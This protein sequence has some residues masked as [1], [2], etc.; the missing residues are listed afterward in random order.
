MWLLIQPNM[1]HIIPQHMSNIKFSKGRTLQNQSPCFSIMEAV[2]RTGTPSTWTNVNIRSLRKSS[3]K[4]R[5]GP[6]AVSFDTRWI[7]PIQSTVTAK[8]FA[9][10]CSLPLPQ[11]QP[12]PY[13]WRKTNSWQDPRQRVSEHLNELMW[14]RSPHNAE[15]F[16][17]SLF[18]DAV[19]NWD[20]SVE[21]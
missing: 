17:H 6:E 14:W 18:N 9:P 1:H 12:A 19:I 3:G 13:F 16:M 5:T 2:Q 15:W 8:C 7:Q 20:Y 4:T 10:C 11:W 21:R